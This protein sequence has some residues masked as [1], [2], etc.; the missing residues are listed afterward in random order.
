MLKFKSSLK[1]F[2][3]IILTAIIVLIIASVIV[4]FFEYYP[5]YV[6]RVCTEESIKEEIHI[7]RPYTYMSCLHNHGINPK[8]SD[9]PLA[10]APF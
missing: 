7:P 1:L 4:Y 9:A 10:P 8:G 5:K 6:D 2:D 3:G